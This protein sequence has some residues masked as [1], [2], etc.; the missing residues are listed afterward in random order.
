MRG[1]KIHMA[2]LP[3][4]GGDE[5]NW[6]E[7]LNQFLIVSHNDDGSLKSA[8]VAHKADDADV[9]HT[10]T[11]ETI[12]GVKTFIA[13]PAVPNPTKNTD[14]TNKT[15]VDTAVLNNAPNDASSTTKGVLSLA[16]DLNGT[17]TSP[18]V[19]STHLAAPLPIA[20]G[21]TGSSTQNFVDT[22]TDQSIA[23]NKTF[24]GKTVLSAFQLTTTPSAGSILT[25]DATGNA[26]WQSP[27]SASQATSTTSGIVK[28]AVFN[29]KD[30]GASGD[31]TADDTTAIQ[32]A[33]N[34]ASSAGGG[35]VYLP[36]GTYKITSTG[37]SL[38]PANNVSVVGDGV[39]HTILQPFGTLSAFRLSGSTTS[40]L[41]NARFAD[42]TVD[43]S[44]Q[45]GT[46][47]TGIKGFYIT[48]LKRCTF[49][50][51][52]IKNTG[53]TG[54]GC[55]FLKDC[56]V[57]DVI[58]ENCGRLGTSAS[59]GA[60]G[61]GIGTSSSWDG[62]TI[63][64]RCITRNN[65][66]A[67]LFFESQDGTAAQG[68]AVIAHYSEGNGE[69]GIGDAG[70]DGLQVIGGITRNNTK[71][72]FA[73]YNGTLGTSAPGKNGSITNL[74]ISGNGSHGFYFDTTYVAG[75]GMFKLRACRI[76]SNGGHGI[77]LNPS[78]TTG[79]DL[80]DVLIADCDIYSN[81][82]AGIYLNGGSGSGYQR[83]N[84]VDNRVRN[85]GQSGTYAVGMYITANITNGCISHNCFTDDQTTKTQK[86][87]L[88]KFGGA[89]SGNFVIEDNDLRGNSTSA[90]IFGGTFGSSVIV[91]DNPGYNPVGASSITVGAS[92]FT[93]TAGI[94]PEE[95]Y[96][97]GGTVSGIV[98]GGITLA[99]ASP[100]RV[101]LE[102][103]QSIVVTYSA[104]PTMVADKC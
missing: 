5:G 24:T 85:N 44:N 26:S 37:S 65:K 82:N 79:N 80:L 50:R 96:I 98:K 97:N 34:A 45:S 83:L 41:L 61:I 14:A 49:E 40:P 9:V 13:S 102:P 47:G 2:R 84:V 73:F 55:D 69:H 74:D 70:C 91:R 94:T 66:R 51:I 100:A 33:I 64:E 92:P 20:Q 16:G 8:A 58:A 42:F 53:A 86:Y 43:G 63:F 18:T 59:T 19:V 27:S 29:V 56:R 46:Y 75:Q 77:S 57:V 38:V 3:Q 30:Y 87:G 60:A 72:G 6:G 104:A 62:G 25:S 52:Y 78:G 21:G 88:D 22:T 90:V 10:A 31:G 11:D 103:N 76:Y 48:Y 68:Y 99:S 54:F 93:Y 81:Q 35:T 23:G 36:K 7:I 15:Y 28:Q 12:G 4:P 71:A 101:H 39:E 95:V 67:G 89:I 32:N 17:A 1:A